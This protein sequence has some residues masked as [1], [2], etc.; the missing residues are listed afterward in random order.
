MSQIV[1]GVTPESSF[2]GLCKSK[3][4]K[5]NE[6]GGLAQ[7]GFKPVSRHKVRIPCRLFWIKP[8]LSEDRGQGMDKNATMRINRKKDACANA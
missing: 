2:T 4:S 5:T 3:R 6:Q 7:P 8:Q 1:R